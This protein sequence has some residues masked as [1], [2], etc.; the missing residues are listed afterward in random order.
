MSEARAA[1]AGM[2]G[3]AADV[4]VDTQ[5]AVE[6]L[7]YRQAEV[8]DARRW[9]DWLALFTDDGRYWMPASPEQT[10]GE[11]VPNIFYE[12]LYLMRVRIKR[13]SHPSAWSQYPPNRT[14][15]VVSNVIVES[16]D[17][18]S[19]DVVAR[20]KFYAAEYR[21]DQL[22][23]FAGSYRH[24]LCRTPDGYRIRLQRVDLV[25]AEGPFEFV[26]QYWL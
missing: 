13:V 24:H 10:T 3:A 21:N 26:L 14:S 19:G 12:D 5:R 7:L 25:N 22:R 2:G 15:H 11:G 16:E 17:G 18:T 20:S 6:Q 4:S 9:D 1:A 23:H 8:L